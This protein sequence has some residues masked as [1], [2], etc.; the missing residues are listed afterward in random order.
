MPTELTTMRIKREA[1]DWEQKKKLIDRFSTA[2]LGVK[3]LSVLPL[4]TSSSFLSLSCQS[5]PPSLHFLERGWLSLVRLQCQ[6]SNWLSP[7]LLLY[8]IPS[9]SAPFSLPSSLL[10]SVFP[11]FYSLSFSYFPRPLSDDIC[12]LPFSFCTTSIAPIVK[13]SRQRSKG[14]GEGSA[15]CSTSGAASRQSQR[16]PLAWEGDGAEAEEA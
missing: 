4:L 14:S 6:N 16:L 3:L 13:C 10:S 2:R 1:N 7:S 8:F 15:Q 5:L 9:L 11:F 12:I